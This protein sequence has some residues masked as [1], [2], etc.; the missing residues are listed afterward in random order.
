MQTKKFLRFGGIAAAAVLMMSACG[1]SNSGGGYGDDNDSA[2]GDKDWSKCAPGADGADL[3]SLEADDDKKVKFAV[4][5]GW[6]ETFASVYT[7]KNLLE[8]DGYEVEV[9]ELEAGPAYSAVGRGD[10]DFHMDM[11]MPTTHAS[12]YDRVKND[13][14]L[15]GCWYGAAQNT[16]AVN[17][18]SPAQ[19]IDDLKT[20]GD[21]YDNTLYGIEAG[22]G[23]TK[24]TKEEVIPDYGLE[25]YEYKISSTPAMLAQVKKSTD[26]GDNVAVT[27]WHPHWAYSKFP[28][29][30]LDD[31][32]DSFGDKE[33]LY[34]VG[35]KDSVKKF[36][37]VSQAVKNFAMTEE[38]LADLEALMFSEDEYN[39][40]TP[41]KAVAE[42]L[43]DNPAFA[44]DFR[45]GKLEG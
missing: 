18:D 25:G 41:E 38:Q 6:D 11:M 19:T 22:A 21:D 16:I 27:L 43:G 3:E 23:L 34:N 9:Q 45:A 2:A 13:I 35:N 40:E 24:V 1:A 29:R 14:D 32:K 28:M 4:F 44:K 20:M 30:D 42:W 15:Q 37:Y 8:Q 33:I 10:I 36:P 5:N 39:G 26:A 12:Y 31:P 7:I 17:E